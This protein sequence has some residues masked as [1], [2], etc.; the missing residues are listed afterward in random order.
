MMANAG[1][2]ERGGAPVLS[3]CPS[4]TALLSVRAVLGLASSQAGGRTDGQGTG[5]TPGQGGSEVELMGKGGVSSIVLHVW[6]KTSSYKRTYLCLPAG[7]VWCLTV[8][9]LK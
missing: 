3:W 1:R 9:K 7:L 2:K 8:A 6:I 4:P 5:S